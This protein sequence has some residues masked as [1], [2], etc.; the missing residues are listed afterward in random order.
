ML[1]SDEAIEEAFSM[2]PDTCFVT[3][4]DFDAFFVR[5][6][7]LSSE[8]DVRPMGRDTQGVKSM[9]LDKNDIVVDMTVIKEDCMVAITRDGYAKRTSLKSYNSSKAFG[10]LLK[11]LECSHKNLSQVNSYHIFIL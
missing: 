10:C 7:R 1:D 5:D 8:K 3:L 6:V 4:L 2:V 9:T 11:N